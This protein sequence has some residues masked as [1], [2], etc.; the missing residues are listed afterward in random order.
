MGQQDLALQGYPRSHLKSDWTY[1]LLCGGKGGG[2]S[3]FQETQTFCK[4]AIDV[5]PF[6]TRNRELTL[7]NSQVAIYTDAAGLNPTNWYLALSATNTLTAAQILAQNNKFSGYSGYNIELTRAKLPQPT[8]SG[9]ASKIWVYIYWGSTALYGD[10][11]YVD[12]S[13]YLTPVKFDFDLRQ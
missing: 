1:S 13:Q 9:W 5:N 7:N 11:I 6:I 2:G 3:P 8:D 10:Q 12:N 4:F